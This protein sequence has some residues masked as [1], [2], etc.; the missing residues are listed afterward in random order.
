MI[1]N[2]KNPRFS[3]EFYRA[4]FKGTRDCQDW[5][6]GQSSKTVL[7]SC[8]LGLYVQI[9][10]QKLFYHKEKVQ[11]MGRDCLL[12]QTENAPMISM[13]SEKIMVNVFSHSN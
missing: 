5:Y 11:E 3:S 1:P 7:H 8:I 10:F 9:R 6:L 12:I 4:K 2:K 13:W